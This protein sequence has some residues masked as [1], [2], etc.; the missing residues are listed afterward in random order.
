MVVK[1]ILNTIEKKAS[2]FGAKAIEEASTPGKK[3]KGW[4]KITAPGVPF[5]VKKIIEGKK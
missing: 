1:S 5:H 2:A 3:V 4:S